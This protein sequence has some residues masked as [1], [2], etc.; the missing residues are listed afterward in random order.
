[1]NTT[2]GGPPRDLLG[3]SE[4]VHATRPEQYVVQRLKDRDALTR[5]SSSVGYRLKAG[6]RKAQIAEAVWTVL[7]RPPTA[8]EYEL[9]ESYLESRK[10]RPDPALQQLVWAL[11]N[12]PEFRFNR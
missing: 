10:D 11:L 9:F 3:A 8:G 6:D 5:D 1:L 2:N 12:S 4:I 7:S